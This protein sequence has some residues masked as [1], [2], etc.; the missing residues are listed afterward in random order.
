MNKVSHPMQIYFQVAFQNKGYLK[1]SLCYT[2]LQQ[3]RHRRAFV[4]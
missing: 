4:F 2:T 3:M 1:L